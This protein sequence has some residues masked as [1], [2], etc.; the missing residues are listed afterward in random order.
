MNIVRHGLILMTENYA[1]CVAFYR[2]AVGLR[3]ANEIIVFDLGGAYLMVETGGH[4]QKDRKSAEANPT[5]FRFNVEDVE[6]ADQ[7]LRDHGV[8]VEVM[9]YDWGT[10]AEFMDPNGNRCALRSETGF[11]I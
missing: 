4:A 10:T 1:D 11:G 6:A 7:E 3:V 5:K 8:A 2:G 9:V